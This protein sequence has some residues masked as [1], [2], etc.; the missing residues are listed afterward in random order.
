MTKKK[1]HPEV[2]CPICDTVFIKDRSN[3]KYCSE[4]CQKNSSR[5]KTGRKYEYKL[6]HRDH[7][8]RAAWLTYDVTRLPETERNLMI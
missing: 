2:N 8:E 4:K 3:K 7:D 1:V 5:K 6:Q